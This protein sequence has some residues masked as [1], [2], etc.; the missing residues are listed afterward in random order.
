MNGTHIVLVDEHVELADGD[1]QV[2]LVELVRDV[3]ADRSERSA[4]LDDGVEET[5][6]VQQLLEGRLQHN[7]N[8]TVNTTPTC[9]SKQS[10]QV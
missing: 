4:L 9:L 3:P 7:A 10:D 5:Q 2:R 8:T 6:P 1:T